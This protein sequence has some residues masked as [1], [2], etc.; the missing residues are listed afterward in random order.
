M[1][2]H[3]LVPFATFFGATAI[4]KGLIKVHIQVR[5]CRSRPPLCAHADDV[6]GQSVFVIFI[7]SQHH[8]ESMVR[9]VERVMPALSAPLDAFVAEQKAKFSSTDAAAAAVPKEVRAPATVSAHS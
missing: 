9:L 5:A 4:G 3:L 7:F 2:G 6:A 8:L 1:S